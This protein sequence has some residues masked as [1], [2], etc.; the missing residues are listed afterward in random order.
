MQRPH[1]FRSWL[2]TW[3]LPR[4]TRARPRSSKTPSPRLSAAVFEP[5]S[6]GA[7]QGC[8]PIDGLPDNDRGAGPL[9][10]TAHDRSRCAGCRT[11]GQRQDT[12]LP[13]SHRRDAAPAQ[14]QAEK[15][16]GGHCHLA[17]EGACAPDLRRRKGAYGPR[18]PPDIWH[19]HGRRQPKGRGRQAGKG[20]QSHHCHAWQAAGP[21][22][23]HAQLCLFQPQDAVH[24]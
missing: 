12:R 15:R 22:A 8:A 11:D 7:N 14:V 2:L 3:R 5:G 24:R 13:G 16:D 20:R 1:W 17:H 10:P 18:P 23:E 4:H 6:V 19:H 21:H 9:Y